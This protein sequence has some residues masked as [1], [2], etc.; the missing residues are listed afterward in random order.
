MVIWLGCDPDIVD[1]LRSDN[2]RIG[3]A[4]SEILF[5]FYRWASPTEC[6]A[7]LKGALTQLDKHNYV[8]DLG[9]DELQHEA[10]R[11]SGG[12]SLAALKSSLW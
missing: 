7:S 6:W 9:L 2:F 1:R 3:D 11:Q 5:S 12:T 8:V 4:T 10:E